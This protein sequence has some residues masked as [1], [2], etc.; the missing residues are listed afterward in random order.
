MHH[1]FSKTF[2]KPGKHVP[3][4]QL[5]G[6][7]RGFVLMFLE[8]SLK[9]TFLAFVVG[10]SATVFFSFFWTSFVPISSCSSRDLAEASRVF[11]RELRYEKKKRWETLVRFS[12]KTFPP[13]KIQISRS[14]P[15]LRLNV[16]MSSLFTFFSFSEWICDAAENKANSHKSRALS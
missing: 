7:G 10:A 9:R 12:R 14:F 4:T 1:L 15:L 5:C 13:A 11:G 8:F 16:L 2:Y 3:L 6:W